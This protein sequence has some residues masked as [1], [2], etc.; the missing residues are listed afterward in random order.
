VTREHFDPQPQVDSILVLLKR[1]LKPV[2]LDASL[3]NA[4]FQHKNQ[5]IRNAFE[6]SAY[7]LKRDKDELRA[8]ADSLEVRDRRVRSLSLDELAWLSGKFREY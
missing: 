6:H 8:F 5:T 3:V 1:K 2:P 7:A 4:L